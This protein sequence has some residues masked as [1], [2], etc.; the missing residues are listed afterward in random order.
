MRL[1]L[2]EVLPED[3]REALDSE[4]ERENQTVNDVAACILYRHF[5][6]ECVRSRTGFRPVADRFK[7]RV[8]ED[9]SRAIRMEAA[10]KSHTVRGVILSILAKHYAVEPIDPRRRRRETA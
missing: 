5:D 4:A 6:L 2:N 3:L 1:V 10:I 9:L 7:L 8:S